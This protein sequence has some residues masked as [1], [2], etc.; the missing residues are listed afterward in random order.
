MRKFIVAAILSTATF[1][2]ATG[3]SLAQGYYGP[4]VAPGYSSRGCAP[5]YRG[6]SG[7]R[8]GAD[9]YWGAG[10]YGYGNDTS[11]DDVRQ[12]NPHSSIRAVR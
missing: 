4:Y 9:T 5:E 8:C 2:G 1:A 6:W 7:Y 12:P 3:P 10:A 11:G